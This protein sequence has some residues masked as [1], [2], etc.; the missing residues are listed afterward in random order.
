MV[1]VGEQGRQVPAGPGVG[2]PDADRERDRPAVGLLAI[3]RT[4]DMSS[5][6][7]S[8]GQPPRLSSEAN[9]V[10]KSSRAT[11]TPSSASWAKKLVVAA[12]VPVCSLTSSASIRPATRSP[13]RD[14]AIRAGNPGSVTQ[15][16]PTLTATGT[17]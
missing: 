4:S 8:T 3:G 9:P 11:R 16:G 15:P 6:S 7:S 10:P 5:L 17:I 14:S 13:C 2:D 1:G 12:A